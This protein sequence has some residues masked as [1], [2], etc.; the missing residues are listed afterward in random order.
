MGVCGEAAALAASLLVL[1]FSHPPWDT[2]RGLGALLTRGRGGGRA[3][4]CPRRRAHGRLLASTAPGRALPVP[5]V[6]TE[7]RQGAL[8]AALGDGKGPIWGAGG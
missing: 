7:A 8:M 6:G 3:K 1:V 5:G 4:P 2:G